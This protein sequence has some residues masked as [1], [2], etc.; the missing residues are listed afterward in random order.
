[1]PNA[2]NTLTTR[3]TPP[4]SDKAEILEL[5]GICL[6]R[7]GKKILDYVDWRVFSGERWIVLGPNGSGKTSLCQIISL[8]LHP[9]AGSI[10]VFGE[11]LG[12]VDVRTLR[13]R[14]GITS[15]ALSR[16]M[17]PGLTT[18]QI[19]VAGKNAAL[20]HW[21]HTYNEMDWQ[22]ARKNLDRVGC[23]NKSEQ[24]FRTLSSGE[25][26]RVL[27][28]RALMTDPDLLILDEPTAGLDLTGREQLIRTLS[29][30]ACDKTAPALVVVTHHV[31][32]IPPGFTHALLLKSGR[33]ARS[34]PIAQVL[35]NG[36]LS[37]CFGLSLEIEQRHGRWRA[38]TTGPEEPF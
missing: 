36:N 13:L 12:Q 11:T 16:M 26:Q 24:P 21:W 33:I 6:T 17:Q 34:G 3:E 38:W 35:T 20:A 10:S 28:A 14:V 22:Q 5:V 29:N 31:D 23:L 7:N 19:V 25:H 1:V 9:S 15:A 2:A 18:E 8:Y 32:E 27:L 30:L 37:D 4:P